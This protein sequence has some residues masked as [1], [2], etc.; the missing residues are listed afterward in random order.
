MK[1][2]LLLIILMATQLFSEEVKIEYKHGCKIP[3]I[4]IQTIR[5]TENK[6]NYK[7][8]IRT[9][10]TD[11][12]QKFN[13]IIKKY[14]HKFPYKEDRKVID[15]FNTD[16]CVSIS[17]DLILNGINNLDLG[18]FQINYKSFPFNLYTYFEKVHSY[19]NACK[20]M[21]EKIKIT[22]KWDWNTVAAYYSLTPSLN[23]SYKN[24]L[25]ENFL[26]LIKN[27]EVLND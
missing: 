12:L 18:L 2:H 9:N 5:L 20:V 3:D 17:T 22:K 27:K 25:I 16:N 7:Y 1:I 23:E 10:D 15:C 14:E 26:F 13:S 19:K 11:T 8:F 21:Y 24:L 6:S 4:I